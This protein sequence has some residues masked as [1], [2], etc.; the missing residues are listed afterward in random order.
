MPEKYGEAKI[1]Q[2]L[3][4]M[5]K[6]EKEAAQGIKSLKIKSINKFLAHK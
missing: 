2:E 6:T 1:K 4:K 3:E 5:D